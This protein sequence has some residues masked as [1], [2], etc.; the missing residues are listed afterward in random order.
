MTRRVPPPSVPQIRRSASL[1]PD[2]IICGWGVERGVQ[3]LSVYIKFDKNLEFIGGG[4]REVLAA[5]P[6]TG[7][8]RGMIGG[9]WLL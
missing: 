5:I 8:L 9:A 7:L 2:R 6:V 3:Q 1:R 4:F